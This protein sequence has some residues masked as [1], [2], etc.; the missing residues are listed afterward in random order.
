LTECFAGSRCFKPVFDGLEGE[1]FLHKP[2]FA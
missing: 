1:K 2:H